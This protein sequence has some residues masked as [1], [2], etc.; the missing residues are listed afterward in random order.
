LPRKEVLAFAYAALR[1]TTEFWKMV[2]DEA[3]KLETRGKISS[4]DHQLLRSSHHVQSE[5]MKLTLGEDDA[6]TEESITTTLS[7]VSA[8]IRKE[9]SERFNQSEAARLK[10]EQKLAEQV[11]QTEAQVAKTNAIKQGIYWRCDRQAGREALALSI[12]VWVI[13]AS[14]AVFG[15]L[16]IS[17]SSKFGW[18]MAAIGVLSGL[19]RLAGTHWEIKPIKF[20]PLYKE[21]RRARL[22][23]AEYAAL[24]IEDES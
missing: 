19:V 6:L 24:S 9:E 17:E 15:F 8:E 12:L 11:A 4:L 20:H 22:Q 16:R 1:P 3:E 7:R 14:V 21:W 5:L 13:Q 18:V 10:T 2:L 23:K